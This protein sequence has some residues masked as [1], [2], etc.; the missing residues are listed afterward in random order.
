MNIQDKGAGRAGGPKGD[1]AEASCKLRLAAGQDP[2]KR[3]QILDGAYRVI[4]RMGYDAASVNDIAREAGV[5]KGTI[6]V[7]FSDKEDMFEALMAHKREQIFDALDAELKKDGTTAERLRRYAIRKTTELCSDPVIRAHRVIIG[8]TERMP[9]MGLRFY[10]RG[11][12]R[13]SKILQDFLGEEV[14]A[15]RL[16]IP[17][18]QLAAAQFFEL[19]MAGLF[20]RRLFGHLPKPPTE[21]EIARIVDAALEMFLCRY[22]VEA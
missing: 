20:R 16:A 14:A 1:G 13:G 17:D 3:L 8:V 21:A 4:E 5:S 19:S 2:A 9:E 10:E 22:G 18:V 12:T 7:Y 15:G 11:N 6:Y